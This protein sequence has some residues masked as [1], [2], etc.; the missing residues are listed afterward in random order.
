MCMVLTY[1]FETWDLHVIIFFSSTIALDVNFGRTYLLEYFSS[2][3]GNEKPQTSFL[4]RF[5]F[6]VVWWIMNQ[7]IKKM[8]TTSNESRTTSSIAAAPTPNNPSG[9]HRVTGINRKSHCSVL[10]IPRLW[11]ESL[12]NTAHNNRGQQ[13]TT[14]PNNHFVMDFWKIIVPLAQ[15]R[16]NVDF[17]LCS[18]RSL[19][20]SSNSTHDQVV[21][22]RPP[23]RHGHI[24]PKINDLIDD[25]RWFHLA[26]SEPKRYLWNDPVIHLVCLSSCS[27]RRMLSMKWPRG[28][29]LVSMMQVLFGY[30][31]CV[32]FQ[33]E[34]ANLNFEV[35][36]D[37][38]YLK[39][40]REC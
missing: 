38:R 17:S 28:A 33:W 23:A 1:Q 16:T 40:F 2:L 19:F 32:L 20:D 37:G 34:K 15:T 3:F 36:G 9:F 29:V 7:S 4:N 39:P 25:L 6:H 35:D 12:V 24:Q 14:P 13:A 30:G 5:M 11:L 18:L 27:F 10:S 31:K 21:F 8:A 26:N 22:S